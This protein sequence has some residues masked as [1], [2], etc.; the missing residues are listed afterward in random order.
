MCDLTTSVWHDVSLS[1]AVYKEVKKKYFEMFD[2]TVQVCDMTH[3]YVWHDSFI[4][5]TCPIHAGDRAESYM[6]H[7]STHT[8][9]WHDVFDSAAGYTEV[10]V[11]VLVSACERQALGDV[12]HDRS[13]A[14]N[15]HSQAQVTS[16]STRRC[17]TW[18]FNCVIWLIHLCD[19]THS[20]VW[21]DS[22]I[23]VTCPIHAGGWFICVTW[24]IHMCDMTHS[25][26]WHDAFMC[27]TW[28]IHMCDMTHT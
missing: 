15:K 7:D 25:Y 5:V 1:A 20:Y 16:T 8:Y 22:F 3:S 14:L 4:W 27:V 19:M 21:H 13:Q 24:R 11:L 10:S 2:M 28:R 6:W 12:W 18:S 23:C 9:M 26:V 17:A